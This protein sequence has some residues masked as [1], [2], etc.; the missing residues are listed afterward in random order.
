MS[1]TSV[2]VNR[3]VRFDDGSFYFAT[4]CIRRIKLSWVLLHIS[5]LILLFLLR[6]RYARHVADIAK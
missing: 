3:V 2:F 4:K 5:M 1:T 6:G